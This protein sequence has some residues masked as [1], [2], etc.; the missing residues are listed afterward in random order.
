MNDYITVDT[1]AS[2]V[3]WD[4][5]LLRDGNSKKHGVHI[6]GHYKDLR[7]QLVRFGKRWYYDEVDDTAACA[8]FRRII[9]AMLAFGCTPNF[10]QTEELVELGQRLCMAEEHP[11]VSPFALVRGHWYTLEHVHELCARNGAVNLQ[12]IHFT[13]RLD[14]M[15]QSIVEDFYRT[16]AE[17]FFTAANR[18]YYLVHEQP[19]RLSDHEVKAIAATAARALILID[20]AGKLDSFRKNASWRRFEIACEDLKLG[21]ESVYADDLFLVA[22]VAGKDDPTTWQEIFQS[23]GIADNE[24]E[25]DDV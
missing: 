18:L 4:L 2:E 13:H 14:S 9:T 21:R 22:R 6:A 15:V 20:E 5:E 7:N 23:F 11:L 1:I 10:E 25:G 3:A 8:A 12:N 16:N 24:D 19:I 17:S